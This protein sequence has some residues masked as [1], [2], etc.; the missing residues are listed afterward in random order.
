[1]YCKEFPQ[2]FQIRRVHRRSEEPVEGDHNPETVYEATCCSCLWLMNRRRA[3]S[4]AAVRYR[5]G[6]KPY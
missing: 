1:M 6:R 2:S 3:Y 5:C 4:F